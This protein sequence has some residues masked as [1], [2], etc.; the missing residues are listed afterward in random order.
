MVDLKDR[1]LVANIGDSEAVLCRRGEADVLSTIHNP[2]KSAKEKE[3][4][5]ASGGKIWQDRLAHPCMNPRFFSIAVSRSIGDMIFKNEVYTKG[6]PSGLIA[7]PSLRSVELQQGDEF[8]L[9]A[10]DGLFD[11]LGYQEAVDLVRAKLPA[12]NNDPE[13]VAKA[14]V[15]VASEK[16]SADNITA[17]LVLFSWAAPASGP[18]PSSTALAPSAPAAPTTSP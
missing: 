1:L 11:V 9:L 5:V 7:T 14:L 6:K 12:L 18:S 17:L 8:L 13:A 16:G 3:R 15:E 10:C 2:S 4:I